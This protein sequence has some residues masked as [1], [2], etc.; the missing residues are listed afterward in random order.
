MNM[1]VERVF[2]M[3]GNPGRFQ[4][5]V[6]VL[7]CC[8]YFPVAVNHLVMAIYGAKTPHHCLKTLSVVDHNSSTEVSAIFNT[9]KKRKN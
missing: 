2:R 5:L 4:V 6:Y 3:L 9:I 1:D 7:L 8:N